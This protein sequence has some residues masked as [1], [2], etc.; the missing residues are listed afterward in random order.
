VLEIVLGGK[1]LDGAKEVWVSGEG[2]S[3]EVLDVREPT[4]AQI[5]ASRERDEVA[6]Q[7]ARLRLKVAPDAALGVR[8]LRIMARSGL[9]NRFRFEIG[10]IPEFLEA[11]PNNTLEHAQP[12]PPL[13]VVVNGQ[14]TNADRDFFRFRATAGERLVFHAKARAI[15]PYLADAVPGWFQAR[16]AL[17]DA[18]S[19]VKI[20]EVDDFRHDPDPVLLWE[21][22]ATGEYI[23]S[24][25]DAVSRGRD[26][27][28]YRLGIG[29]LP[30]VTDI[31]PIGAPAGKTVTVTARGVN[32][33]SRSHSNPAGGALAA[34]A[35]G[36][37]VSPAPEIPPLR[38]DVVQFRTHSDK[39]RAGIQ[40]LALETVAGLANARLFAFGALPEV[41][42]PAAAHDIPARAWR[43]NP[44]VVINGRID[45]PGGADCYSFAASKE[46]SFVI[47]VMARRLDS[48]LDA[49][50]RVGPED[51]FSVPPKPQASKD[52]GDG[53]ARRKSASKN[54]DLRGK[55]EAKGA[56]DARPPRP[57]RPALTTTAPAN[58]DTKDERHGLVTHHADP[59][60]QFTA[61]RSGTYYVTIED[62]QGKGGPEF[63]YRLRIAPPQPDFELRVMPDNMGA[64]AGGN[65]VV[66]LKAFRADGFEGPI[67]LRMDGLPAGFELGSASIPAGKKAATFTL[68]VP[69]DAR[70]GVYRPKFYAEADVAPASGNAP[71]RRVRHDV[72]AAEELMQ[73]F[74]YYHTVPVA[75]SYLTV[76]PPSSFIVEAFPQFA[77]VVRREESVAATTASKAAASPASSAVGKTDAKMSATPANAPSPRPLLIPL[78]ASAAKKGKGGGTASAP[79]LLPAV[80]EVEIPVRVLPNPAAAIAPGSS[81][82]DPKSGGKPAASGV[83]PADGAS[84]KRKRPEARRPEEARARQAFV[85][86]QATRGGR[87]I[88]AIPANI[89]AEGGEGVIRIQCDMP[90]RV[91]EEGVLIIEGVQN[92]K[93]RRLSVVA[94]ALPFKVIPAGT[95]KK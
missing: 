74:F 42:E 7:T 70:P 19:G 31:H 16:I 30:F 34:P 55:K 21:V 52:R 13:P 24:I 9:S 25:W 84:S 73:A 69:P 41:H 60:V 44:P 35:R 23:I 4:A 45:V 29:C 50:L 89:P 15:K 27:F 94:P 43:V 65:A 95:V 79:L 11:E 49:R 64:P 88:V 86:V 14:I 77:R 78:P 6:S 83:A 59:R 53:V 10:G 76:G 58:D 28:V 18:A 75:Q 47:D 36:S 85:R 67:H 3:G 20:A 38:L 62:T 81:A 8:D 17:F 91:G 90:N 72:A 93:G 61:P 46:Q 54:E 2:V 12:L 68:A 39:A 57:A 82:S 40:P 22:P 51:A 87:G 71:P 48:P 92:L 1:S 33:L 63:S 32:L 66:Q 80:G 26:D 37:P 5:K 56:N